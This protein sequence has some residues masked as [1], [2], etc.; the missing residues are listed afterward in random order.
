MINNSTKNVKKSCLLSSKIHQNSSRLR[1]LNK[2][3]RFLMCQLVDEC[4]SEYSESSL[5][6]LVDDDSDLDDDD[7]LPELIDDDCSDSDS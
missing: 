2:R 7:S 4:A 1:F 6:D 5:P 3:G